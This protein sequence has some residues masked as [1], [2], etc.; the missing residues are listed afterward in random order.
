MKRPIPALA[1]CAGIVL[2][3]AGCSKTDDPPLPKV[4]QQVR[5]AQGTVSMPALPSTPLPDPVVPKGAEAPSPVP[6]QAG[7]T[8]SPAFKD[9]GKTDPHK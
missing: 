7:D 9:G 3:A 6:G 8:S 1:I 5:S 2:F 4:D